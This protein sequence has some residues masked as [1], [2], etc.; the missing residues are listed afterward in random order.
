[1]T[2]IPI[3]TITGSRKELLRAGIE[4]T[5]RCAEAGYPAT[6]LTV[7]L[8]NDVLITMNN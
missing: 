1:M 2:P 5:T 3:T 7:T 6:A 8:S 4:F